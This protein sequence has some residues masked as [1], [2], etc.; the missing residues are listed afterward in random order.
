MSI[1]EAES[2]T[3]VHPLVTDVEMLSREER[4]HVLWYACDGGDLS[5]VKSVIRA[6]CD[7][8][9]FHRGHTPLMMA[10]IR[11]HDDVVKE[12]ILAGC[13]VDL[14]SSKCFVDWFRSIS[15]MVSAWPAMLVWAVAILSLIMVYNA[16]VQTQCYWLLVLTIALHFFSE[17]SFKVS[18]VLKMKK[19]TKCMAWAG[20][21]PAA[22]LVWRVVGTVASQLIVPA[23]ELMAVAV[24]VLVTVTILIALTGVGVVKV[25][26]QVTGTGSGVVAVAVAVA[27]GVAVAVAGMGTWAGT[28]NKMYVSVGPD[29]IGK[30]V[31]ATGILA[32]FL[33]MAMA[34]AGAV[35]FAVAIVVIVTVIVANT[36]WMILVNA[37]LQSEYTPRILPGVLMAALTPIGAIRKMRTLTIAGMTALHYAAWYDHITCGTHLV[38]AGANVHAENMY[39]RT[40]LHI[41]S[42]KFRAAV[43]RVQ[44]H[45]PK[46]VIAVIGNTEYGKSTLIAALQSESRS[47]LQSLVY[48][49]AQ[50]YNITRRT[51]GIEIVSFSSAKY[52]EVLFYDF[53]GQSDYHGPHQPFLEAMLS[54]VGVSV[55]VLLLVKATEGQHVITQQLR[56]WLQPVAL[57]STPSTPHVIVVGSFLDQAKSEAARM[58]C[59]SAERVSFPES[60]KAISS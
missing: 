56:R 54:K 12:L 35:L 45:P 8:D 18:R 15:K 6:G 43:Q 32:L 14:Q 55:T 17:D 37:V 27:V 2:Y 31:A 57:T 44:S 1:L 34:G 42:R 3:A 20:I 11:G 40:P 52:G 53:A 5:M 26:K 38:E 9:H 22:V 7:V 60:D 13:K 36:G 21:V 23:T 39:Y 47:L 48:K 49:L 50:V 51:A 33:S 28:E 10:S 16:W 4:N 59:F 29:T 30:V 46:Q 24:T 58:H 25:V 19:K 41:C